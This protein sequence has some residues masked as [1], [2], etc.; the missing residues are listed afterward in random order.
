MKV[1]VET[2]HYAVVKTPG[3]DK[4]QDD[5]ENVMSNVLNTCEELK[6]KGYKPLHYVPRI[7]AWVCEKIR[8]T[9]A[10]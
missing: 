10:A 9:K 4:G 5:W 7:N 3:M 6:S 1:F 2:D 8:F